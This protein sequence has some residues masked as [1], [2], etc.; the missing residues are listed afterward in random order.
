MKSLK[1]KLLDSMP[2]L[3]LSHGENSVLRALVNR[4]GG[5][6]DRCWP[7]NKTIAKEV[8]LSARSV[9][10]Y[11]AALVKKGVLRTEAR[12]LSNGRQTSNI[13]TASWCPDTVLDKAHKTYDARGDAD[14]GVRH[15]AD[16]GVRVGRT[17]MSSPT[18][19][20]E[21]EKASSIK[22]D[23]IALS[24][25]SHGNPHIEPSYE[26]KEGTSDKKRRRFLYA[27]KARKE[28][29]ELSREKRNMNSMN[30][31]KK[32]DAAKFPKGIKA[33]DVIATKGQYGKKASLSD[34]KKN[35]VRIWR[36]LVYKYN[37]AD[38]IPAVTAKEAGMLKAINKHCTEAGL[39]YTT[40]L[41]L[42]LGRWGAFVTAG[43]T[44]SGGY[45]RPVT[46]SVSFV[47]GHINTLIKLTPPRKYVKPV[48]VKSES[49]PKLTITL[50]EK[51]DEGDRL[52]TVEDYRIAFGRGKKGD[53]K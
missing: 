47:A 1:G 22:G 18:L 46:P 21:I 28:K 38:F 35:V 32:R 3:D 9:R 2:A 29:T 48:E 20:S 17:R 15:M 53:S 39:S 14:I 45:T 30:S 5:G 49:K 40:Q 44:D 16:M 26:P 10:R 8:S 52:A 27:F 34:D 51:V 19:G 23:E 12:F 43:V 31:D 4:M 36:E 37:S 11:L 25:K 50:K 13:Y 42:A 41:D 7:S 24:G 6:K 33:S